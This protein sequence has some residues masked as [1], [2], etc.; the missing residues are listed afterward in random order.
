MR[1]EPPFAATTTCGCWG[2]VPMTPL[3]TFELPIAGSMGLL[4]SSGSK[5]LRLGSC[6][7]SPAARSAATNPM[8][9]WRAPFSLSLADGGETVVGGHDDIRGVV[10]PQRLQGLLD[11]GQCAVGGAQRR[12]RRRPV[13]SAVAL[14]VLRAVGIAA[15]VHQHEGLAE[16]LEPRQ[17]HLHGHFEEVLL[18]REVRRRR[19]R[20]CCCRC[21]RARRPA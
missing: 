6:R 8:G 4:L 9:S 10:K 20:T 17:H 3:A 15:P 21:A 13:D 11:R 7:C 14:R 2:S 18:L 1:S 19:C 16:L 5:S 12:H